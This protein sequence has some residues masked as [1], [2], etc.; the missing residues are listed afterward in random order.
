MSLWV[1]LPA[2]ISSAVCASA[3]RLGVELPPGP[4]FGVDGTLERFVRIPYV[5]PAE[6]LTEAIGLLSRA[7]RSVTGTATPHDSTVVI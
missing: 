1:Q 7:W 4:R 5:L 2:P 6:Q 3:S